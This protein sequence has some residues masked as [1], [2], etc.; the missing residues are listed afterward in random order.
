MPMNQTQQSSKQN[1]LLV[2]L[3]LMIKCESYMKKKLTLQSKIIGKGS[4]TKYL[5]VL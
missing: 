5:V 2:S 3:K 1:K 4:L